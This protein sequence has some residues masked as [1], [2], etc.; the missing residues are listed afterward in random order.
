[1]FVLTMPRTGS[2]EFCIKL[3]ESMTKLTKKNSIFLSEFLNPTAGDQF[4]QYNVALRHFDSNKDLPITVTLLKFSGDIS[5]LESLAQ[6]GRIATAKTSVLYEQDT[7]TF[8]NVKELNEYVASESVNR[9]AFLNAVSQYN[10][11]VVVKQF[12]NGLRYF[13]SYMLNNNNAIFYYRKNLTDMIFSHA[14]KIHYLD[15]NFF[16]TNNFTSTGNVE[17]FKFLGHNFKG[18]QPLLTPHSNMKVNN[19]EG[20][21]KVD[22]EVLKYVQD[23]NLHKQLSVVAYEDFFA[24]KNYSFKFD[25]TT[26]TDSISDFVEHKMNYATT[27]QSAYFANY[28]ELKQC[29]SDYLSMLRPDFVKELGLYI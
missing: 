5:K 28:K 22:F 29:I 19:V 14:F 4:G 7:V 17:N 2:T 16:A 11:N 12:S 25:G 13:E 8:D 24:A 6:L 21:V 23:N 1:M 9:V 18:T 27:D 20:I 26:L 10:I 15:N 3:A